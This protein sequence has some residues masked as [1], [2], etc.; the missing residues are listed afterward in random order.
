MTKETYQKMLNSLYPK[1]GVTIKKA[2]TMERQEYKDGEWVQRAPYVELVLNIKNREVMEEEFK[3][4]SLV[5]A[6]SLMSDE[7]EKVTGLEV[8][9]LLL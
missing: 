6:V 3:R 4:S 2:R 1:M 9:L 7:F 8:N 5:S